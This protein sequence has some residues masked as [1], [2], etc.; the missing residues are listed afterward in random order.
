VN[1]GS[2]GDHRRMSS[3]LQA[4]SKTDHSRPANR[5]YPQ[6][7]TNTG[8]QFGGVLFMDWKFKW[9]T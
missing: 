8:A 3:G 7:L 4:L 2:D 5:L 6:R 9:T 1:I